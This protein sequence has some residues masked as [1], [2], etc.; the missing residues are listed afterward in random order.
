MPGT[1]GGAGTRNRL[2]VMSVLGLTGAAA[3][4]I[5]RQMPGAPLIALPYGRGQFG[6]DREMT[7]RT[8]VGL[9]RNPNAGAVLLVG[10]D[11]TRLDAVA[12]GVA[13]AEIA[14]GE[15]VHVHNMRSLRG[16]REDGR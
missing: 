5:A 2:L 4:R 14:A 8:L 16:R 7:R 6:A 13:A 11:R 12:E 10:A 3:A 15:H 9:G 1:Y